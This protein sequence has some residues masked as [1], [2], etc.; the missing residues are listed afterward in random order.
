VRQT[1]RPFAGRSNH[2]T[3][4]Q[5]HRHP[6]KEKQAKIRRGAPAS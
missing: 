2:M 4:A 6:L 5:K 3:Q 1:L